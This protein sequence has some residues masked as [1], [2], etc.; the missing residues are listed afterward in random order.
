VSLSR[1]LTSE[2]G[3]L[4]V[5]LLAA[6]IVGGVIGALFMTVDTGVDTARRDRDWNAAINVADAGIQQAVSTIRDGDVEA[7]CTGGTCEGDLPSGGSYVA[8]YNPTPEGWRVCSIGSYNERE[9]EACADFD[10]NLLFGGAGVVGKDQVRIDGSA[11]GI[12][13][14]IIIGTSGEFVN[15]GNACDAIEEVEIYEPSDEDNPC[16]GKPITRSSRTFHNVAEFEFA[17]PEGLCY[18]VEPWESYPGQPASDDDRDPWVYGEDYCVRRADLPQNADISL[19]GNP[20]DGPVR[21]FVDPGSTGAAAAKYPGQGSVNVDGKAT[22]LQ[23]FIRQGEVDLDM[24]GNTS[25]NAVWYAPDSVCDIRGNTTFT[26]A[27]LC[28]Q[29]RIGGNLDFVVPDDIRS[30]RHGPTVLTRWY[31]P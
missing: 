20:A 31:E 22:D 6:I 11:S 25:I 17:D 9:R 30:L 8:T 16:P 21:V 1:R 24:K 5:V 13:S 4:P 14:P 27:I 19:Q 12:S 15:V 10:E 7:T 28:K 18:A 2:A 3:S 23:F 29:S 26:G